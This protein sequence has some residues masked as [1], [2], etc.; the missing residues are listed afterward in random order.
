MVHYLPLELLFQIRNQYGYTALSVAI[1]S[2]HLDLIQAIFV[3]C[4]YQFEAKNMMNLVDNQQKNA[5]VYAK[6]NDLENQIQSFIDKLPD[7]A[8]G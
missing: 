6:E 8:L 5:W 4:K 1:Q 3:K 7:I 2:Y